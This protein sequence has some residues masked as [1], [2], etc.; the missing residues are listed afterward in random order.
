[1]PCVN[2]CA[3]QLSDLSSMP[4][5]PGGGHETEAIVD[6]AAAA[7]RKKKKRGRETP[8]SSLALSI[9]WVHSEKTAVYE[10]GSEL[11]IDTKSSSA[12]NLDFPAY[13]TVSNT[14]LLFI[15]YAVCDIFVTAA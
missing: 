8:E 3:G 15:S 14:F 13:K 2:N 4:S 1:M 10:L 6:G 11:S 12:L 5:G 7:G 9:V